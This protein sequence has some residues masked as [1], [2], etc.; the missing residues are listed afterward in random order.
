MIKKHV[1]VNRKM[2]MV[3]SERGVVSRRRKIIFTSLTSHHSLLALLA[4]PLFLLAFSHNSYSQKIEYS[5]RTFKTPYADAMQ[6]VANVG[7]YHH[8]LCF[9]AGKAPTVNIFNAGLQ[10]HARKEIDLKLKE[11]CDLRLVQF[12]GFY[13][14][15]IHPV[16]TAK[17]ELFR[18]TGTGEI[19]SLS[20]IFQAFV[21]KELGKN[22]STLQLV[23]QQEELFVVAHAYYDA[24]KKM[25]S[26]VV[27]LDKDFNPLLARK[28]MYAFDNGSET[29]QQSMLAGNSL[30]VLKVSRSDEKGN[31][32]DVVKIDLSNGRSIIKSFNSGTHL[33]SSPAFS[34]NA[35]DSGILV[36][37]IIREPIGERFQRAVFI[38][39]LDH[40]LQEVTP[41][42]LLRSQ[43]RNNTVANFLLPK[44]SPAG[45]LSMNSVSRM[46]SSLGVASPQFYEPE[47]GAAF[48]L[49]GVPNLAGYYFTGNSYP[50]GVRV[51][52][53]NEKFKIINDS[54]VADNRYVYDVS[55]SPFAQF[56]INNK[57]HLLLLQNFSENRRALLKVSIT[58]NGEVTTQGIRVF[59]KYEYLLPQLQTVDN[60][61]VIIPYTHRRQVGLV[62]ITIE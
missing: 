57:S 13:F 48:T 12:K 35:K 6:L 43:F 31:S 36:Y 46:R 26:S 7:G 29:L 62:K 40:L 27:Q 15:Y 50:S 8:V 44:G 54:L 1:L 18:I 41:G 59:E 51:T 37:S 47:S 17:H 2:I 23:N 53:L 42:T 3:S 9:T 11:N 4:I 39:Q 20:N 24:I 49:A 21:E 14:L 38:S 34:F 32:L 33:Y 5:R 55:P 61:Y 45:W 60:S 56:S 22:T 58:D 16:G 10:L 30:L 28:V 25:G 19:I 52:V